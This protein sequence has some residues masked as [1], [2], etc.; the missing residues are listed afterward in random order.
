[1]QVPHTGLEFSK[2]IIHCWKRFWVPGR[3]RS[4][5]RW[6]TVKG[7]GHRVLKE[8]SGF[9]FY[10][11]PHSQL[12]LVGRFTKRRF[13][14]NVSSCLHT[15]YCF[16]LLQTNIMR[17]ISSDSLSGCKD[18]HI[19]PSMSNNGRSQHPGQL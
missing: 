2:K 5:D 11:S 4:H 14:P 7:Q 17:Q 13:H 9:D 3:S 15:A 19:D 8:M 6:V 16:L 18:P 10:P 1:M 12:P